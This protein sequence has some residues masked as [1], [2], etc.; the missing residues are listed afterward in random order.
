MIWDR[1]HKKGEVH[2]NLNAIKS[3]CLRTRK[4]NVINA[5]DGSQWLSNGQAA[6]I[7]E[8]VHI[9]TGCLPELLNLS[10]NQKEKCV[11]IGEETTDARYHRD[12]TLT[13]ATYCEDIGAIWYNGWLYRAIQYRERVMF[14]LAANLRPTENGLADAG[15]NRYEAR[16]MDGDVKIAVYNG[17][18]VEAILDPMPDAVA[19]AIKEQATIISA[20]ELYTVGACH[21]EVAADELDE[22]MTI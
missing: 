2:M 12:G 4:F 9:T 3:C 13:T 18:F 19:R 6:W 7:V 5:E 1:S 10:E 14:L 15:Y 16:I 21:A 8:G 11:F 17:M 22:Q 20:R